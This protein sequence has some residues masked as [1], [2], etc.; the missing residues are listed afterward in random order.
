[1]AFLTYVAVWR[2]IRLKEVADL[3]ELVRLPRIS[4][5]GEPH[6]AKNLSLD[7]NK[8]KKLL[9]WEP[10]WGFEKTVEKTIIWYKNFHLKKVKAIDACLSDI[11]NFI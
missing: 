6:E 9:G 11:N 7:I 10:I 5:R 3:R 2:Q 4:A 8:A 1:M